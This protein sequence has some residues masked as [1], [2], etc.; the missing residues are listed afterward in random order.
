VDFLLSLHYETRIRETPFDLVFDDYISLR[1]LLSDHILLLT[2]WDRGSLEASLL[3]GTTPATKTHQSYQSNANY[4][5]DSPV[6]AM[7]QISLY[8]DQIAASLDV[9][10]SS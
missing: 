3:C 1:H 4:N 8:H 5:N 6:S 7:V 2:A 10:C 9:L